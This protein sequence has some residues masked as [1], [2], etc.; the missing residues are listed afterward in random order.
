VIE[1]EGSDGPMFLGASCAMVGGNSS[2]IER[3]WEGLWGTIRNMK[4]R[5][6]REVEC[7]DRRPPI[8]QRRPTRALGYLETEGIS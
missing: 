6:G 8:Y 4:L 2:L 3:G 5:Q 7:G 1:L